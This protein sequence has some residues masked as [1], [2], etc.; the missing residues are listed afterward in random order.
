M[1]F[2]LSIMTFLAIFGFKSEVEPQ[3]V[4]AKKIAE[5]SRILKATNNLQVTGTGGGIKDEKIR[6]FMADYAIFKDVQIEEARSNIVKLTEFYLHKINNDLELKP[7][8]ITYPMTHV[9]L[10]L[11][12][13]Y[14]QPNGKMS[15]LLTFAYMNGKTV[16]YSR[17]DY[18]TGS[19]VDIYEETYEEALAIVN[20][21]K[22][23]PE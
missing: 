13:S 21:Q 23:A 14:L 7:L 22:N 11:G 9:N 20:G 16:R 1:T 3:D 15:S 10:E 12:N 5:Y 18:S 2:F 6:L 19:L 17:Y 4:L 8:L